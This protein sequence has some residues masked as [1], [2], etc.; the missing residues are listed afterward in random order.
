[1]KVGEWATFPD[2]DGVLVRGKVVAVERQTCGDIEE[3]IYT[4]QQW[5]E[6]AALKYL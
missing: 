5:P 4:L 3:T 6:S 1:V 2:N